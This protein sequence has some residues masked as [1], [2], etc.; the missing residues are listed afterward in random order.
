[1]V[2]P[3]LRGN[4]PDWI[5][6]SASGNRVGPSCVIVSRPETP[7]GHSRESVRAMNTT[8]SELSSSLIVADSSSHWNHSHMRNSLPTKSREAS[9]G[10]QATSL[11]E[12]LGTNG[13][14]DASS[15]L[16]VR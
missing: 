1:M 10:I 4:L 15:T 5:A 11:G 3:A 6:R 14:G 16:R 9:S 12:R 2:R 8:T 13:D 7:R